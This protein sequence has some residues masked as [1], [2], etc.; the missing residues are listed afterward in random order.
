MERGSP[1]VRLAWALV[2]LLLLLDRTTVA[3]TSC[4]DLAAYW[5]LD[6]S[7]STIA[8]VSG[9]DGTCGP[10]PLPIDGRIDGAR[11]FDA[12]TVVAVPPDPAF[13]F[14]ASFTMEI[15]ARPT[16]TGTRIYLGRF[17]DT[18]SLEIWIG[19]V[20]SAAAL[21]FS[22]SGGTDD[23]FLQ[24][25]QSLLDGAWH[26]IVGVYDATLGEATLYVDAVPVAT[27]PVAFTTP[28]D[29]ATAPMQ[30]G[31][32]QSTS[33]SFPTVGGLDSAVLYSAAL[34]A[35]QV[36]T[37]HDAGLNGASAVCDVT[38]PVFT[39][40]PPTQVSPDG[41]YLYTAASF[42]IDEPVLSLI[43]APATASF[44]VLPNGRALLSWMPTIGDL[45]PHDV[46]I[47][48]T[49]SVGVAHQMFTLSVVPPLDCPAGV[50][51]YWPLDDPGVIFRDEFGGNDAS[52]TGATC[53][54]QEDLGLR[55]TAQSELSAPADPSFDFPA[56]SSFSLEAWVQLATTGSQIFLGRFDENT[57]LQVWI[58]QTA[59][60]RAS[61][62]FADAD[63]SD[64]IFLSGTQNLLN[65]QPH[66]IVAVHDASVQ[67]ARLYVDGLPVTSA[68]VAF[69]GAFA[70]PT[71][72][73]HLG[74]MQSLA[75]D[76]HFTGLLHEL[77]V[78]GIALDDTAVADRFAEGFGVPYCDPTCP[79]ILVDPAG[80]MAPEGTVAS[81]EVIASGTPELQYQWLKD[82]S[83]IVGATRPTFTIPSTVPADAGEY[84][85]EVSNGCGT[86]VSAIAELIVDLPP[87]I[88][89]PPLDVQVCE[90]GRVSFSVEAI[91]AQPLSYQWRFDGAD[92][93]GAIDPAF[94]IPMVTLA[95]AGTYD[96]V[97]TNSVDVAVSDPAVLIVDT[98]PIIEVEP[99]S[100]VACLGD[101]VLFT[102]A[103]SGAGPLTYQWRF[104][105][106]DIPGAT[107]S[108]L[109][110]P[111]VEPSAAGDYDVVVTNGCG[112][113][114]SAAAVLSLEGPPAIVM[115]PIGQLVC[116]GS[117]VTLQF[118]VD[119]PT[120][121]TY[122][123]RKNGIAI[124]GATGSELTITS[125]STADA[126]N[127]DVAATNACGPTLSPPAGL[128]PR[129]VPVILFDPLDQEVCAGSAAAFA[130]FATDLGPLSYQWYFDGV[131]IPDATDNILVVD[132]VTPDSAG[133]YAVEVSND[134]GP[135]TSGSA[136]L[137][138]RTVPSLIALTPSQGVCDGAGLDLEVMVEGT[139]PFAY[140]WYFDGAAIAGE[141]EATLSLTAVTDAEAGR[142][143]VLVTNGCGQSFSR[144]ATTGSCFV[145]IAVP[146][147][148]TTSPQSLTFCPD[149]EVGFSVEVSGGLAPYAYQWRRDGVPIPDAVESSLTFTAA[150]TDDGAEIDVVVT[151]ACES[152]TSDIA[153][154]AI[155]VQGCLPPFLRGDSNQDGTVDLSDTIYT[156]AYLF[157]KG[158]LACEAATDVN[159]D[160][161]IDIT[162]PIVILDYFFAGGPP[163]E[164]PFP[165]CGADP[166]LDVLTCETSTCP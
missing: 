108:T 139:G 38:L 155:D 158:T 3:Q 120:P 63:G 45:G 165:D 26:H 60:G 90:D 81:F 119:S 67:E 50:I 113:T 94:S 40:T 107:M 142:Y 65:F 9:L 160:G 84:Q 82:G 96:V 86:V 133:L 111:D 110:L 106:A 164:I 136:T 80:V 91:G 123:W 51:S 48:A 35:T 14:D 87:E 114:P 128:V 64:S 8:E 103:A 54:I 151:S 4:P 53:P 10:C 36:T 89:T 37:R 43:E 30:I 32:L 149:D 6:G 2:L 33:G 145:S 22:D 112:S 129:D 68:P 69:T 42:G 117:S 126:G 61:L 16:A 115:P 88:V 57:S 85:V 49:N 143:D 72:P 166:T 58:G 153:M 52:C 79:T 138:V 116:L 1:F 25:T 144:T 44:S 150:A 83:P 55:F 17:D 105:G 28:C 5:P 12:L 121:V 23:A 163:P 73:L 15:W 154:M 27:T 11:E 146:T 24:G 130:V 46:I 7:G 137:S 76:F 157:Q 29:S 71:A 125:F 95:D 109:A 20:G 131:P 141:T 152:V 78:H 47:E 140:Q 13:D 99:A 93:P 70:S 147:E 97:V 18:S 21:F 159:D 100:Q 161:S 31:R 101:V 34:D 102:T 98:V 156:L 122:Q 104:D 62:F 124:P 77:I 118:V 41:A 148:I 39:S 59:T 162:D 74:W 132:P 19:Q 127:Y 56:G 92:I 134:C 135:S 75:G 66:H